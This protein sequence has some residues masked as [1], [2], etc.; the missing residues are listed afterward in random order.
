MS[1]SCPNRTWWLYSRGMDE[2]YSDQL[3][4]WL[5]Q[6]GLAGTPEPDIVRGFAIVASWLEFRLLARWC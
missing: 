1:G 4:E 6:A 5:I 3:S 2:T